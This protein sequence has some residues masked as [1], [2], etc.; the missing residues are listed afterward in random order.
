[1]P[2]NR[3]RP[4]EPPTCSSFYAPPVPETSLC[5]S[6]RRLNLEQLHLE[7][8]D[9]PF[10]LSFFSST[11]A[12]KKNGRGFSQL[13]TWKGGSSSATSAR[14][15][16]HLFVNKHSTDERLETEFQ[17]VRSSFFGGRILFLISRAWEKAYLGLV[18]ALFFRWFFYLSRFFILIET[19]QRQRWSFR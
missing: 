15:M 14:E 5:S 17:I 7:S 4:T 3:T 19:R 11:F 13:E 6:S 12:F 9:E 10:S 8:I 2:G 1:M 18:I 16:V